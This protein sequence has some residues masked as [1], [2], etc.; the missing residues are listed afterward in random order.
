[1]PHLLDAI[2]V[3]RFLFGEQEMVTNMLLSGLDFAY[4]LTELKTKKTLNHEKPNRLRS[5]RSRTQSKVL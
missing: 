3:H 1:M 4:I 5:K 2:S